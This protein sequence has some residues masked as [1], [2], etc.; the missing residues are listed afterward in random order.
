MS[1]H[2]EPYIPPFKKFAV[3]D[4]W[5]LSSLRAFLFDEYHQHFHK[6]PNKIPAS[7]DALIDQFNRHMFAAVKS[8]RVTGAGL[9]TRDAFAMIDEPLYYSQE[10]L[11]EIK[12]R[13]Y[14]V[15]DGLIEARESGDWSTA[16]GLLKELHENMKDFV[17]SGG[18]MPKA[19]NDP[20]PNTPIGEPH[21]HADNH[22]DIIFSRRGDQWEV[23]IDKTV[24]INNVDGMAYIEF[25]FQRPNE[26]IPCTAL[27]R[28]KNEREIDENERGI[29]GARNE[30]LVNSG[31]EGITEPPGGQHHNSDYPDAQSYKQLKEMVLSL[32]HDLD[33]A[34]KNQSAD[35]E[36]IRREY[37]QN[38]KLLNSMYDRNGKPRDESAAETKARKNVSRAIQRA[39]KNIQK[40]L[41]EMRNYLKHI[42]TGGEVIFSPPP[43][44]KFR[45]K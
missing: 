19:D 6:D 35:T 7:T 4:L 27:M 42:Q 33:D 23:G 21:K 44:L 26:R 30:H 9:N 14:P 34:E 37:D 22:P 13:G 8:G 28:L 16:E 15:P 11:K 5:A 3:E 32:K 43:D 36:T 38:F 24:M 29:F 10:L 25:L 39:V 18:K 31:Q 41:P 1:D 45:I 12:F 40:N 17:S 2:S 20:S